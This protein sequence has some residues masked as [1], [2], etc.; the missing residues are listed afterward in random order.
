MN[1]FLAKLM[2]VFVALPALGL[3]HVSHKAIDEERFNSM[4]SEERY[5]LPNIAATRAL[6]MGQQSFVAD[7]FWLR[8]VLAYSD[9]M[10]NCSKDDVLWLR[11]MLD[12]V[13]SLDPDWRTL[14]GG[15]CITKIQI[16]EIETGKP[17]NRET[18]SKG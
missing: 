15:L 2:P 13:S 8:A 6:S 17:K 10:P 3:A 12:T 16:Q 1:G 18:G 4:T 5:F 14:L 9:F 7:L 11:L